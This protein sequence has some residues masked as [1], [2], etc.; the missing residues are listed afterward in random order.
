MSL[1]SAPSSSRISRRRAAVRL[2]P[3]STFPPGNS[4]RPARRPPAGRS[5]MRTRPSF[6]MTA[7]TTSI[8]SRLSFLGRGMISWIPSRAA[9]QA[10]R[11]GQA[12][13][14]GLRL[15]QT[16]APS[17]IMAWLNSPGASPGKTVARKAP[18]FLSTLG[19]AGPRRPSTLM[20]TRRTLASMTGR[21]RA[22]GEAQDGGRGVGPEP[23]QPPKGRFVVGDL[24]AVL[25]DDGLGRRVQVPGPLIIAQPL[26]F[27][28]GPS[29][30]GPGPG[31][32][33]SGKTSSQR[34]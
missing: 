8:L 34:S 11:T 20:R 18:S 10:A 23:G 9:R 22:V 13:H 19:T 12:R 21:G 14:W 33:T 17:S 15:R 24:A 6:S 28:A 29:G 7:T 27:P 2:S 4:Q 25:P 30:A 16:S 32:L 26:P 1:I 31:L 5:W 3:G